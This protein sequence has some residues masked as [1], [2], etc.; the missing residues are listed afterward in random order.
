MKPAAAR[1]DTALGEFILPYEDVRLS[2]DPDRALMEFLESTYRAAAD[3]GGW[4][5]GML[6]CGTGRP[7]HPRS[8]G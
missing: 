4:D 2:G 8:V 6:E 5:T 3:L 1:F 7:L